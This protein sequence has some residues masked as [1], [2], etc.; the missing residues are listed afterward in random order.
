[1]YRFTHHGIKVQL[2]FFP[3]KNKGIRLKLSSALLKISSVSLS[4]YLSPLP[5]F[6][7]VYRMML[8]INYLLS[9]GTLPF[10]THYSV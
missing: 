10:T 7:K 8:L 6:L 2:F 4:T 1:M 5:V 9:E 3:K